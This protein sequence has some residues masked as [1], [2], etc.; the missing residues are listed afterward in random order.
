MRKPWLILIGGLAL[1]LLAYGGSYLV[2][3]APERCLMSSRHP[4]LA[5]LQKEF[6]LSDAEIKRVSELHKAY[7]TGCAERCLRIDAKA[8]EAKRLLAES[9][10]VTPNVEKLLQEAA[11]L[12]AG[13][14]KAMLEHF[15]EVS[16]TM[17]P[18]QGRRYLDWI[19][20]R[21]L[22]PSHDTMT[23]ESSAAAHEHRHE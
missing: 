13:C 12:R 3:S 1:A 21:T 18:E 17:P 6:Q 10:K 14:Q 4:E 22:G 7:L 16:K 5:W 8:E 2:G 20:A 23:S 9:G 11:L 19:T 15:Y